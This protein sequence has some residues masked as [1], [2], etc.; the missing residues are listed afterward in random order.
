MGFGKS[1]QAVAN[2]LKDKGEPFRVVEGTE[3]CDFTGIESVIKSPGIPLR[4]PWVV[5]ARKRH[6]K[7]IGEIDLALEELKEKTLLGVT[8]SNGKTTTVSAIAHVLGERAVACGNIGTPLLSV[9][10]H[11]AEIFVIELSSFQLETIEEKPYFHAAALLNCTPNHLDHHASMEEYEA[12]K[13]RLKKCVKPRGEFFTQKT[14]EK[15]SQEGYRGEAAAHDR[16][17]FAAAFLLCQTV[18]VTRKEFDE[19][20][21]TFRKPP[22][23]L[24]WVRTFLGVDFINDSKATSVDAVLKGLLAMTK[25]VVLI[26]GGVDKGGDFTKWIPIFRK[27]VR[28]VFAI[29]SASVRIEKELTPII[30]VERE[31]SLEAAMEKACQMAKE[32]ECILLS[33]GCSSYD[34]FKSFE[35]RG[36]AFKTFV[37]RK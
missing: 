15:V 19:K 31:E 23:R 27:K 22:H 26:A 5:G 32:G 10:D 14:I 11:P 4:H 34:Q 2:Y 7:V 36:N 13:W 16:E 18:G 33:P 20:L 21:K 12:A 1:G 24:E 9:I 35:E 28:K 8:G 29:G 25:P 6:L 3:E 37:N 17:N 30:Q